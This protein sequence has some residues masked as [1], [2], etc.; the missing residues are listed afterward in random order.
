MMPFSKWGAKFWIWGKSG[1]NEKKWIS[2][3]TIARNFFSGWRED[4]KGFKLQCPS[5][6]WKY[7]NRPI[8][9]FFVGGGVIGSST[10][11]LRFWIQNRFKSEELK[12]YIQI[13]FTVSRN[14]IYESRT[15]KIMLHLFLR[16]WN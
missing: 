11:W 12:K 9:S 13:Q 3:K 10:F 14:S 5:F 4:L 8:R 6:K 15:Q 7:I 1:R 2:G 16:Y